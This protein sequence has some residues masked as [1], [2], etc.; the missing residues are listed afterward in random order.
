MKNTSVKRYFLRFGFTVGEKG[1]PNFCR[2]KTE[3]ENG[4]THGSQAQET[5]HRGN[6]KLHKR[7]LRFIAF[8]YT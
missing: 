1:Q 8:I 4:H 5:S 7:Y 3:S 6:G 2:S